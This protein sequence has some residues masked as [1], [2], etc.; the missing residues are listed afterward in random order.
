M[1]EIENLREHQKTSDEDLNKDFKQFKT[2][3]AGKRF[4]LFLAKFKKNKSKEREPCNSP[5]MV[6][7]VCEQLIYYLFFPHYPTIVSILTRMYYN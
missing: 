5:I 2:W 3:V 1:A 4:E 7:C 6:A